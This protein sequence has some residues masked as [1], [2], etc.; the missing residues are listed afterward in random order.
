MTREQY[1]S[2]HPGD[3][4]IDGKPIIYKSLLYFGIVELTAKDGTVFYKS[5]EELHEFYTT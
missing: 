1:D 4:T 2:L 3:L 5:M